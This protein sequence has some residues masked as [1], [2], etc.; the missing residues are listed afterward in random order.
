MNSPGHGPKGV[1]DNGHECFG[2]VG[3]FL[4]P[5]PPDGRPAAKTLGS[6]MGVEVLVLSI[7]H[8]SFFDIGVY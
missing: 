2:R 7:F 8:G 6:E 5:S 3:C 4:P 1:L